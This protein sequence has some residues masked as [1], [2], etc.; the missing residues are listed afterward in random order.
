MAGLFIEDQ[1]TPK[2]CGHIEGKSVVGTSDMIQKIRAAGGHPSRSGTRCDRPYGRASRRRGLTAPS[3]AWY[4]YA[5]AGADM[6]FVEAPESEEELAA[7]GRAAP[8]P[9]MVT[10]VEGGR[11]PLE[12][13]RALYPDHMVS[14]SERSEI[15]GLDHFVELEDRYR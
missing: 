4:A 1:A 7:I 6:V 13:V 9:L 10:L 11:T 8:V 14:L 5:D 12:D 15:L 3:A 2:R